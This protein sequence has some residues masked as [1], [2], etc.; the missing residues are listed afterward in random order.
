[1]IKPI[2]PT[3]KIGTQLACTLG[4]CSCLCSKLE[5]TSSYALRNFLS[6]LQRSVSH[7]L[8]W[9]TGLVTL[10]AIY[11][12]N[13]A[14]VLES[15]F[16]AT[17]SGFLAYGNICYQVARIGRLKRVTVR[18]PALDLSINRDMAPA[19][20]IL[21]PSYKEEIGIIRQTLISAALQDYPNKRIVLL[22]D[23]PPAPKSKTD[24]AAI[25]SARSL[26]FELQNYLNV[27]AQKVAEAHE[28]FLHRNT[29]N[30]CTAADECI[31]LSECYLWLSDWLEK[32][33]KHCG[34]ESHT[35]I[36]FTEIVF[37]EPAD[38]FRR[39]SAWW[40]E[41][42]NQIT[43]EQEKHLAEEIGAAYTRLADRFKAEFDVFERKQYCNLSH[44]PNKAMNL[45]SYLSVMGKRVRPVPYKHGIA[46][47]ETSV[48]RGSRLIPDTPY[49]ITLDADSLL[50]PEYAR[51]LIELMEKPEHARTAVAQTPYSAIPNA[52]GRL[53]RTAGATTD[54]QYLVHQ[55]FTYYGATFWVGANALLRKSALKEICV[56]KQE[57]GNTIRRYIQDRT[58]IEDTES[59]VDLL[60]KGWV[61]YNHPDRLAYS[62]TP[63]DFGSLI[64][65][66]ARW[67]NGGLLILPKLLSFLRQTRI[68]N[69]TVPQALVQIHYLTSLAFAPLSVLL[70]LVIP[71]SSQL[72]TPWMVV[73]ACPYFVLYARDLGLI[74]YRPI[75]DLFRSYVLNLLL[76][77]V[78]LMGAL[79]SLQQAILG[80]KIPFK[81][82]PKIAGRTRISGLHHTLQLAMVIS[83]IGL[84]FYY[85]SSSRWIAGAFP[86][87]N[88]ALL[89]YGIQHF[90]GFTEIKNDLIF[91]WKEMFAK[92][93]DIA[94]HVCR[95][96]KASYV[97]TTSPPLSCLFLPTTCLSR[98]S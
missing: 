21:I 63:P 16:F 64:I 24:L 88:A 40:R 90:I 97:V 82:T 77:P 12:T 25:W 91:S 27:P 80:T 86:L 28:A 60:A 42:C 52:P 74:G 55:G 98:S 76:I 34:C 69:N 41:R 89:L 50:K 36:W 39:L 43:T 62:A 58:V 71:F 9:S 8:L 65:Q 6:P 30:T 78:H 19:L 57:E 96:I 45:N 18:R 61:L 33:A 94:A 20:S 73:A 92:L 44:E 10:K 13:V 51:T 5:N 67:A 22:L 54:I 46:L 79:T 70:I 49:V 3:H 93:S 87:A 23:D 85:A 66:R 32:E 15:L 7:C 95:D 84:G 56:E 38:V 26:P 81:R 37:R 59:T 2:F 68:D 72:M 48:L 53:E 47:E 1:M 31:R 17:I 35:D 29:R 75:R 11:E 4:S 83:S 14:R